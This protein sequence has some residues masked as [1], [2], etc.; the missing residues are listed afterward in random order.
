MRETPALDMLHKKEAA[1]VRYLRYHRCREIA[2]V[3][4]NRLH[5]LGAFPE[6]KANRDRQHQRQAAADQT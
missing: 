2:A 3:R 1:M 6:Q 5:N 4:N